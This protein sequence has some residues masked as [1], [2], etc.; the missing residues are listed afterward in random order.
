MQRHKRLER[1]VRVGFWSAP[2]H[3]QT[4]HS[5]AER[6]RQRH[7]S[8]AATMTAAACSANDRLSRGS[9]SSLWLLVP[10]FALEIR[11]GIVERGFEAFAICQGG[12]EAG[13][14]DL[15]RILLANCF[16][17]A[18]GVHARVAEIGRASCRER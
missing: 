6:F 18:E 10:L 5:V 4:N 11:H 1:L 7:S 14:I 13:H 3:A 16:P 8:A 17:L 9:P 2:R 12:V 15:A